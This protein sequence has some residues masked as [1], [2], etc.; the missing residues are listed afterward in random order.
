V[1]G[2]LCIAGKIW[3]AYVLLECWF[4][5]VPA[6]FRRSICPTLAKVMPD[7]SW[8][9]AWLVLEYIGN[10][11]CPGFAGKRIKW[12][13]GLTLSLSGLHT[14][15]SKNQWGR[16]STIYERRRMPSVVVGVASPSSPCARPLLCRRGRRSSDHHWRSKMSE[17]ECHHIHHVRWEFS[18]KDST[19]RKSARDE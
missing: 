10:I 19:D 5:F 14:W 4:I 7:F 9:L 18:R 1:Y 8:I 6:N 2:H 16:V 15:Q 13:F 3:V 11:E 12:H 17:R